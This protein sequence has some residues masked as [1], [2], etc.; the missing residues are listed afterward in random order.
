MGIVTIGALDY[1]FGARRSLIFVGLSCIT[2][3]GGV[4]LQPVLLFGSLN[5]NRRYMRIFNGHVVFRPQH[6]LFLVKRTY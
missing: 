4:F 2:L 1:L 5:M 6:Q 3:N